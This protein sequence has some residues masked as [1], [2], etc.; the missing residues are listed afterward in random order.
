MAD[1][2]RAIKTLLEAQ[3]PTL[4]TPSHFLVAV[5]GG[6]DSLALGWAAQFVITNAGYTLEAVVV[7]HG[8]QD[9]S[10]EVADKAVDTL[11]GMGLRARV[12]TV[13]VGT[14]GGI[15]HAAREAR[16][17]AL[18]AVAEETGATAVL[19]GH[20]MDDQAET[21]ILGLARGS[22]PSSI[23]AMAP[24][25]DLWWRPFLGLR[26]ETT[27]QVCVDA[28]ISWWDDPHNTDDRFLRPR[29][30]H[31]VLDVMESELGPGVVE[32]LG[33]TAD[34]IRADDEYLD[35]LSAQALE[36]HLGDISAGKLSVEAMKGVAAPIGS[37]ML[38]AAIAGF[39]GTTLHRVHTDQ[40]LALV[41]NWHG[42]GPIDI[43]GV[44]VERVDN[45]LVFHLR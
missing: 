44:S 5:S 26:R 27:R 23:S 17:N 32:A 4:P 22:G 41:T 18:R 24:V 25:S 10:A 14:D 36:E 16:Y 33:A 2:R 31:R 8:L 7:D 11:V 37:R 42:Q 6:A 40:V 1:A 21:V 15:E 9:G 38:R 20:T 39:A 19:L 45:Y 28:G 34:L 29:V 13:E 35:L 43:P 3:D 30:R 12:V